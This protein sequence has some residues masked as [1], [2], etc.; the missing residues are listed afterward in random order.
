MPDQDTGPLEATRD[1]LAAV[2]AAASAELRV[3][4]IALTAM[5]VLALLAGI[6]LAAAWLMAMLAVGLLLTGQG[7]PPEVALLSL[8]L[9]QVALAW[10]LWSGL[11]RCSRQL[12]LGRFLER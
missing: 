10:T 4:G 6:V 12:R 1:E 8:S 11:K 7:L 2:T 5:A 9:V 3:A